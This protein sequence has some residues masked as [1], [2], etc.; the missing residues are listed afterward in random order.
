MKGLPSDRFGALHTKGPA[1]S[2]GLSLPECHTGLPRSLASPR[3]PPLLVGRW[4]WPF[5]FP[6]A[7]PAGH[8]L[9]NSMETRN[10][11]KPCG[12]GAVSHNLHEETRTR[13][14]ARLQCC[15][16][17]APH[18]GSLG[19]ACSELVKS[20]QAFVVL[21]TSPLG[22]AS[23]MGLSLL[24]GRLIPSSGTAEPVPCQQQCCRE[25]FPDCPTNILF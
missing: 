2:R 19:C 5:S 17:V 12:E 21:G 20:T 18:N 16:S 25:F 8:H 3:C 23:E 13:G 22:C 15:S 6:P 9:Q 4:P 11:Q 14:P 24:S 10:L 1:P 7:P